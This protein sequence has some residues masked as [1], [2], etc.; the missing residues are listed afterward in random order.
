MKRNVG[1]TD[2]M[3]RMGAG[4]AMLVCAVMAPLPA[5]VRI[6]AFGATGLY[7]LFTAV[8]GTCFGYRLLGRSTCPTELSR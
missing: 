4:L 7:M 5:A 3:L 2:R 1:G 8:S 6:G